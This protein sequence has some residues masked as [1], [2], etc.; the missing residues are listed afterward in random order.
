MARQPIFCFV[1]IEKAAGMTLHALLRNNFPF[2]YVTVTPWYLWSNEVGAELTAE[3]VRGLARALPNLRGFGGHTTRSYCGYAEAVGRA[4]RYFTF[5][6]EP[7]ARYV[8]HYKHQVHAMNKGWTL[9]TF[10]NER[11][12]DDYMTVRL[13]G[14]RD[15]ERA[16]R[17]L[18][19]AFCCVGLM[20]RFDESLLLL[21]S[22]LGY[23]TM[24]LRYQRENESRAPGGGREA[25]GDPSVQERLRS[26]NR[27]DL[28]LYRFACEE[29]YP[30]QVEAYGAGLSADLT[31]LQTANRGY[32]FPAW[33]RAAWTAYRR[34][35]TRPIESWL[36][37]R[38]EGR[39]SAE[40][41][42]GGAS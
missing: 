5:L 11:R 29:L 21:R 6:R 41:K 19:E 7:I 30:A 8:S 35:L 16:K 39:R 25:L 12:F 31:A 24:D 32:R 20:E 1:H 37:R 18:R 15:V 13:A 26:A 36:H 28:E 4:V 23:P 17:Q 14:C 3:E 27:L 9:D 2:S 10:L 40:S 33:R 22:A 34:L 38:A 42:G